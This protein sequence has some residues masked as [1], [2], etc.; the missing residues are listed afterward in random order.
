MK[1]PQLYYQQFMSKNRLVLY[2]EGFESLDNT[3]NLFFASYEQLN[4]ST[5]LC[6]RVWVGVMR[7]RTLMINAITALTDNERYVTLDFKEDRMK[8]LKVFLGPCRI[9]VS[10]CLSV[11]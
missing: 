1:K 3:I 7:V 4:R 11:L 10:V 8:E 2:G 9:L 6:A 5:L